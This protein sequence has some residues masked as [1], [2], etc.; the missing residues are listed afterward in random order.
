MEVHDDHAKER[1]APQNVERRNA[2]GR[3]GTAAGSTPGR[4]AAGTRKD[5]SHT[6]T[7]RPTRELLQ[8]LGTT[9]IGPGGSVTR[10]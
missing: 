6:L 7:A 10:P 5:R 4:G 2:N 9:D 1:E 3:F 8:L